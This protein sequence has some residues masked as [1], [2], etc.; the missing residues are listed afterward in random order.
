MSAAYNTVK[1]ELLQKA[2]DLLPLPKGAVDQECPYFFWSG[3]GDPRTFVRD[4]T[5]TMTMVFKASGVTGAC[6]H[7]FRHTLATEVL[8][9]GGTFEPKNGS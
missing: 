7:R 4:V 5:R 8:E 3:N 2:L 1:P 6:S 9:L